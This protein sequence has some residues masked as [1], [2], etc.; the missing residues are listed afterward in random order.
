MDFRVG[1]GYDSH[2]LEIGRKLFIGGIEIPFHKG[3]V[4]HSDG[5]A[6]IHAIC[7]ALLGAA[8]LQDIGTHFP[9]NDDQYK[10]ID[11]KRLLVKT[12]DLILQRQWTINNIDAT[13]VLE[14]PRL[15]PFKEHIKRCLADLLGVDG[16]RI[17]IKAKSNE[18]M[19]DIG[20]GEGVAAFAAVT[21]G[22]Q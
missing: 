7:D 8:G 1:F 19:G 11:S 4:A 13:V 10:N 20:R 18:K 14:E 16:D 5:D 21:I 3:A 22:K 12:K 9:D 15:S 2:R 17:A 6:L